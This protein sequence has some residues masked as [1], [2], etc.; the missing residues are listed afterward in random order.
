VSAAEFARI[1]VPIVGLWCLGAA[2]FGTYRRPGWRTL[3]PNW[4]VAVAGGV[5]LRRLIFDRPADVPALL[6]FLGVAL[7][8]TLLFLSARRVVALRLGLAGARPTPAE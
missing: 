5:L 8:F 3:L 1:W 4:V 2:A 7:A 6:T